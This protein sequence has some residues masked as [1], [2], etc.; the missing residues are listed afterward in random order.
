MKAKSP[1]MKKTTGL[2]KVVVASAG[3]GSQSL[4]SC[5]SEGGLK[6]LCNP[7]GKNTPAN[8]NFR[9]RI[10]INTLGQFCDITTKG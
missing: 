8:G 5:L 10:G 1:E 4:T 3:R 9:A 6:Y 2:A 7:R